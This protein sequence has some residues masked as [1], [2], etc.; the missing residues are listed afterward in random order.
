MQH[1]WN[2]SDLSSFLLN[3][4]WLRNDVLAEATCLASLQQVPGAAN[5]PVAV[6]EAQSMCGGSFEPGAPTTASFINGFFSIANLGQFARVGN[7]AL[8][9]RWGIPELLNLH[10]AAKWDAAGVA[11]DLFLYTI[12]SRTVGHGVLSVTGDEA[13]DALVYAHCASERFGSN[14]TVTVF[15]ANPSLEAVSLA[16]SKPALPRIEYILTAPGGDLASQ[17]PVL[18]GDEERPLALGPDGSLP[19]MDGHFCG[20]EGCADGLVLPPRSQG[21]FVLLAARAD[22]ECAQQ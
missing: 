10:G 2:K 7:V 18:N 13:S 6:T 20:A 14:G 3:S 9:A 16:V 11:S 12:Y 19:P 21:F 17:T 22:G 1:H 4:S 15:G 8:V 5:L